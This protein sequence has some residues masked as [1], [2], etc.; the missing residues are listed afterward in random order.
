MC[1]NKEIIFVEE[2]FKRLEEQKIAYCILRNAD[3]VKQGDAHDID[4]AVDEKHLADFENVLKECGDEFGWKLH[5]KSGTAK[6][7]YN[8]KCYH[9]YFIDS[10]KI[11]IVHID[12]FPTFNWNGYVLLDNSV[13]IEEI[14]TDS[15][16][17][18]ANPAVEA[19]TKLFIRLLHNGY[20]K[21]KYKQYIQEIFVSRKDKVLNTMRQFM[22][23][24]ASESVLEYVAN[25]AWDKL[26]KDREVWVKEIKSR[27]KKNKISH[28]RHLMRKTIYKTGIMVAFEGTDGSG[29]STI[30]EGLKVV[31]ENTYPEGMFDYY[32]WRPGVIMKEKKNEDGTAK[33]V[34]EPH[35]KKPYGKLK[36]F[37]KFMFFNVD[38]ILGYWLKVRWQLC[39]GHLVVFDRYYYDYYMD[40]IRYRLNISDRVLKMFQ[41]LIPKPDITFLL[42]GDA[43]VLYERKKEIPVE[44]IEFQIQN[45]L[46]NKDNFHNSVIVDVNQSAEAAVKA[47]AEAILSSSKEGGK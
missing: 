31:L 32:H 24:K 26:E 23:E 47:V 37:A 21:T 11:Y 8:I 25:G 35:A 22:S 6:D 40:K 20:V 10:E 9:Y 43:S 41:I 3:E 1:K 42:I 7:R 38:Y 19:V 15:V 2:F 33:V 12:V 5:S 34:S 4:M 44:E 30:I 16:F 46:R 29:K 39:K 27:A 28:M 14:E 45:L 18:K 17:H 36:S 13:L